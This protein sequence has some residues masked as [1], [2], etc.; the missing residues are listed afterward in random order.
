MTYDDARARIL[1]GRRPI[2]HDGVCLDLL[3]SLAQ[4]IDARARE[5][6][7]RS[8][9]S[10]N[11]GGWRSDSLLRWTSP[12]T[13][14]LIGTL[15]E[16]THALDLEAWAMVN[17]RGSSHPRHVHRG[18]LIAGVYYVRP[19]GSGTPPTIFEVQGGPEIH[20]EPLAGRLVLFPSDLYHSVPAYH[21]DEPR[22]TVAFDV[23]AV[24]S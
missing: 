16:L 8:A 23:R 20:V 11:R 6:G 10:L 5:L 13:R 14:T 17:R 12:A 3:D 24:A 7:E 18:A 9:P 2:V 22:V 15:R 4:E 21:G 19:G 1:P